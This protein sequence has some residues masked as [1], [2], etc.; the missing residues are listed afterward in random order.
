MH[1]FVHR[2]NK[3]WGPFED[4]VLKEGAATKE[5]RPDDLIWKPGMLD[6]MRAEELPGLFTLERKSV[7]SGVGEHVSHR[8]EFAAQERYAAP[9]KTVRSNVILTH[10]HGGYSL[11]V[12]YW[13]VGALLAILFVAAQSVL[14]T[15]V[16]SK[17]LGAQGSGATIV[18]FFAISTVFVA[19]QTVGIWRSAG[20]HVTRGGKAFWA[21]AAKLMVVL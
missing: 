15:F 9:T 11:G 1:W 7:P 2:D 8:D 16:V 5:L 14:E 19:W 6:W 3:N 4:E 21:A 13:V 10:W 20:K 18:L 17:G 12:A